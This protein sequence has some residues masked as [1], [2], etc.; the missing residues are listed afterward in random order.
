MQTGE[1][2][3]NRSQHDPKALGNTREMLKEVIPKA[4]ERFH[5]ALDEIEL[6]IVSSILHDHE[7]LDVMTIDTTY[8][9]WLFR[10]GLCLEP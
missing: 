1:V 8:F 10:T 2:F 3:R 6:E 4:N 7:L 9:H 5:E